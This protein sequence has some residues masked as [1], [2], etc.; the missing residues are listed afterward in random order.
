MNILITGAHGFLGR[1]VVAAFK[2]YYPGIRLRT[3]SSNECDLLNYV[4][5]GRTIR[6]CHTD[7]VIHLAARVGGITSNV[8]RPAMFLAHNLT[9]GINILDW[10]ARNK[11]KK[12]VTVGT[13][14]S[15]S[16]NEE[17]L[18]EDFLGTALP[19]NETAPYGIAKLVLLE[20][21]KNYHRQNN[22][23][24]SYLIPSNLYGPGD[25][26]DH[27]VA[28]LLRKI[29][30]TTGTVRL[31]GDGTQARDFLHVNDC[32]RA[33]VLA[34]TRPAF[35]CAVN[36]GTEVPSTIKWVA[37]Q[38]KNF[39]GSRAVLKFSGKGPVGT[40]RRYMDCRRAQELL[41]WSPRVAFPLGLKDCVDSY[42]Q[43]FP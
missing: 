20:L 11:I 43:E 38:I 4:T 17:R 6:Q 36:L 37:N 7:V 28:D 30:R 35:N 32:A 33:I 27:V 40:P 8:K 19:E 5:V 29:V 14:C 23:R 18:R 25:A 31:W 16:G 1:A 22:L 2:R 39:S 21:C 12:F 3:P 41:D 10:C 26:S 24:F 13:A 9:M 34:A 15:Y 42:M